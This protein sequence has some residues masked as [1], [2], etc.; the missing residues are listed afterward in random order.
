[1]EM[2]GIGSVAIITVITF[3]VAEAIKAT[4]L[5][6]KWLPVICGICG[7]ILGCVAY[8]FMPGYPANDWLT[9]IAV[10]IVSGWGATGAHQTY[11]QFVKDGDNK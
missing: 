7:G 10:G 5:D 8:K 1:M 4:S 2:F 11:H 9:A 3:L 6:N